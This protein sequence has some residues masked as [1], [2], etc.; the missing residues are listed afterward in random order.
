MSASAAGDRVEQRRERAAIQPTAR[1]PSVTAYPLSDRDAPARSAISDLGWPSAGV[2]GHE[3]AAATNHWPIDDAAEDRRTGA[4]AADGI[5]R[6]ARDARIAV[7]AA[8]ARCRRSQ[9]RV[10]SR[11]P[12]P[13]TGQASYRVRHGQRERHPSRRMRSSAPVGSG[14]RRARHATRPLDEQRHREKRR[15]RAAAARSSACSA[16]RARSD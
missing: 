11:A 2:V 8:P 15:R 4:I 5:A 10:A 14:R 16:G 9:R 13:I 12:R 7:V 1:R 3:E 6:E